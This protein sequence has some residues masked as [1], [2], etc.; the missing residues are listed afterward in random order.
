VS[1]DSG[2]F[3]AFDL[4]VGVGWFLCG[5]ARCCRSR[6][7]G[8]PEATPEGLGLDAGEERRRLITQGP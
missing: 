8:W 3:L 6:G 5:N 4:G 7:Q 1:K 2:G